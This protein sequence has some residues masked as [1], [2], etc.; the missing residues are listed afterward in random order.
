[1]L[2]EAEPREEPTLILPPFRGCDCLNTSSH[3]EVRSNSGGFMSCRWQ[4]PL[5]IQNFPGF[6]KHMTIKEM[7]PWSPSGLPQPEGGSCMTW[8]GVSHSGKMKNYSLTKKRRRIKCF[9]CNC[10]ETMVVLYL[11]IYL[12]QSCPTLLQPVDCSPPGCSVHGILQARIL[13]WVAIPFSRGSSQ[14]RDWTHLS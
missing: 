1:M 14:L 5:L 8:L 12:I 4:N 7:G 10:L 6:S 3:R 11:M 9:K 2:W 13:G